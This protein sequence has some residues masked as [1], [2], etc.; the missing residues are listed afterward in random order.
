QIGKHYEIGIRHYFTPDIRA[1]LTMFRADIKNEIF[2]NP[3]TYENTNHPKTRHEGIEI[4]VRADLLKKFLVFA[5]YTYE[6]AK[7]RARP[8]KNNF[9]P[10]VPRHRGN[11]GIQIHNLIPGLIFSANYHWVGSTYLISD[12]ANRYNKLRRYHTADARLSYNYKGIRAFVGVDNITDRRYSE[13]AVVGGSG[14]SYYP[15]P[16]RRWTAGI[17][18]GL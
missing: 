8:F 13:Y 10:A 6:R 16:E 5:N 15:A 4:G 18:F 17:E 11:L 3:L 1:N 9:V 7:F 14:A 2:Y 12:Q